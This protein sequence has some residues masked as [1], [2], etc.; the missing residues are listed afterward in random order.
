M[1]QLHIEE[2]PLL[3]VARLLR[4]QGFDLADCAGFALAQEGIRAGNSLGIL[5]REQAK[6]FL[7]I[8]PVRPRRKH[9]GTIWFRENGANSKKWILKVFGRDFVPVLQPVAMAIQQT[10]H[11]TVVVKLVSESPQ[12][13]IFLRDGDM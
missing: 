11:I 7:G 6:K 12:E 8:I 13:E 1:D 5:Q 9:I 10:C 4:E 2:A 3:I